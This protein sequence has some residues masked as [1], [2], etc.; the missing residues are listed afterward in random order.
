MT[1]INDLQ[2]GE[3]VR[4]YNDPLFPTQQRGRA[5]VRFYKTTVENQARSKEAGVKVYD[6]VEH[7]EY[8]IPG[9]LKARP[10]EKVVPA[11]HEQVYPEEYAA[12]KKGVNAP[13]S[14]TPF[15]HWP[16]I[17]DAQA[18]TLRGFDINSVEELA[19]TNDNTFMNLG[20]GFREL[21]EAAARFVKAKHD[22]AYI[23]QQQ[24]QIDDLQ[25]QIA[26]LTG[27]GDQVAQSDKPKRGRPRKVETE[28]TE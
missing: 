5:K 20:P 27:G 11:W 15:E 1:D 19:E 14:G 9:D 8:I 3:F 25:R 22:T 2:D 28:T 18:K 10:V 17:N 21:K 12:F 7:C 4:S 26:E 13:I 24:S 6:E 23:E 16:G